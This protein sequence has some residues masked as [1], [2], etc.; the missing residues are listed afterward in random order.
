MVEVDCGLRTE[1][2]LF[3]DDRRQ[4][5]AAAAAA[6]LAGTILLQAR[7]AGRIAVAV[8]GLLT[9]KETEP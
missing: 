9:R 1:A 3:T 5:I 6:R 7:K 4:N 8:M 2:L